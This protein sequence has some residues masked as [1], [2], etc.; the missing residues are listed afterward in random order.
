MTELQTPGTDHS[1]FDALC[2][3]IDDYRPLVP[4][5][6]TGTSQPQP[7]IDE[8]Q[9]AASLDAHILAGLVSP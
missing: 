1:E 6:I 3:Q 2:E 4:R 8:A 9:N 5:R 7:G